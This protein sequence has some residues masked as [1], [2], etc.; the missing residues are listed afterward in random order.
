MREFGFGRERQFTS[1]NCVNLNCIACKDGLCF[2]EPNLS[3][4][5]DPSNSLIYRT[6]RSEAVGQSDRVLLEEL[7]QW[8][9]HR[10]RQRQLQKLPRWVTVGYEGQERKNKE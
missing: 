1:R 9:L 2:D 7:H 3:E 8:K 5:S 10:V 6:R 4:G